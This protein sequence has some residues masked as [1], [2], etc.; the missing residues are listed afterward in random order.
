MYE[1]WSFM[2]ILGRGISIKGSHRRSGHRASSKAGRAKVPDSSKKRLLTHTGLGSET[3]IESLC[4]VRD[5]GRCQEGGVRRAESWVRNVME[6]EW[7]ATTVSACQACKFSCTQNFGHCKISE[8]MHKPL[9][10]MCCPFNQSGALFI[11]QAPLWSSYGQP[12]TC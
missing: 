11:K 2:Q 1:N 5:L 4:F 8:W 12:L 6:A 7:D 3:L 9:C 10:A